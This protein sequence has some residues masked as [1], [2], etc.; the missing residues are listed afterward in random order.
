MVRWLVA[1]IL[2]IAPGLRLLITS[3][4]RLKSPG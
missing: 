1:D 3:R 2:Q 4:E